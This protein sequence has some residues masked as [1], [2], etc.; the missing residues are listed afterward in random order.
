MKHVFVFDVKLFSDQ[1]L[2]MDGIIDSIGQYFRAQEKPDFSI[3]LSRYPR[4]AIEL[5]Q[6]QVDEATEGDIVRVYAIGGEEI[7][8]DC[9]NG[10]AGLPNTELAVVPYGDLSDFL[11]IFGEGKA[12]LFRDIP[13]LV[14]A[15]AIPTDMIDVG[16]NYVFNTCLIGFATTTTIKTKEIIK[17]LGKGLGSFFLLKMIMISFS[18]L[19]SA[20]DKQIVARYYRITIDD[21]EYNGNYSFI[22]VANG[23]FFAGKKTASAQAMPDDGWLDVALIKSAGALKTIGS[24]KK[25]TRGKTP[26]NCILMKAKKIT[27]QSDEPMWI[28]LDCEFLQDTNITFEVIPG[29]VNF[30]TVN[31]MTY[32]NSQ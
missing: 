11:C 13:S 14:E 25:Y 16:H 24:V 1:I 9:L 17:M 3:Q 26:S 20:F 4:D 12:E 5:I 22:N 29:A 7:L 32:Q 6:R 2:K 10:V 8:F 23:P 30:V 28:Q 31:N 15:A 21:K 18:N 27:I 19:F